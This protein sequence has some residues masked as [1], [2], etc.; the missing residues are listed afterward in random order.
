MKLP[1][2][3]EHEHT[4]E[5]GTAPQVSIPAPQS[6]QP[7]PRKGK[8]CLWWSLGCL[9]LLIIGGLVAG[10]FFVGAFSGASLSTLGDFSSGNYATELPAY[11]EVII[12]GDALADEKILLLELNGVILHGTGGGGLAGLSGDFTASEGIEAALVQASEDDSVKGALIY[13]NSPGGSVSA[14]DD[15]QHAIELFQATGRPVVSYYG[16]TAASGGV[17]ATASSDYIVASPPTLT[18]SIGVIF[19]TLNLR[20]LMEQYG[21][22][23]VTFRSGE[24]KDILSYSREVTD[25]E[26]E[27]MQ[28]IID[29]DFAAFKNLITTY[30]SVP[31]TSEVFDGRILSANQALEAGLVD[32][33][34][35]YEDALAILAKE[36]KV[37]ADYTLMTYQEPFSFADFLYG[38]GYTFGQKKGIASEL[39]DL[40]RQRSQVMYLWQ[41]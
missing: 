2:K 22:E 15:I 21:V 25:E 8:G 5:P 36:S 20:G 7:Q 27:I 14:S 11:D 41:P 35:Y 18:G 24:H 32:E 23:Q 29:E 37:S 17:Y 10:S 39:Q 9:G 4:P 1:M 13:V 30:R 6:L 34:A 33:V 28:S 19:E 12:E 16:E 31:E 3:Q 38:A 26:R 40:L